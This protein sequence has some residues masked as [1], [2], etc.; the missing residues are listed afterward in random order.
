MIIRDGSTVTL[1]YTVTDEEGAVVDPGAEPITYLHGDLEGLFPKLQADLAGKGLNDTVRTVLAPDDAFGPY[2]RSLVRME[3]RARF[4]FDVGVGL[5][6]EG[7]DDQGQPIIFVVTEVDGDRI[8]LDGNHP[9]AGLTL[10]FS[11][12]VTAIQQAA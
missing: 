6:L 11:C 8:V 9:L 12:T 7:V 5:Q 1:A 3:H 4:D 2:D 10:V